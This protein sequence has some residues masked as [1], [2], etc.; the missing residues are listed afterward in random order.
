IA[1]AVDIDRLVLRLVLAAEVEEGGK[2][3]DAG[4]PPAMLAAKPVQ[5]AGDAALIA[6][7]DRDHRIVGVAAFHVEADDRVAMLKRGGERAPDISGSA[8]DQHD[9]L[10]GHG[11]SPGGWSL[12]G[13][14]R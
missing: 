6:E 10:V 13:G 4:D 14:R 3:H 2:M 9:R 5:R 11:C 8:R 1:A 12:T 7:V